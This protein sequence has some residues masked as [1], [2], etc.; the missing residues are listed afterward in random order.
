MYSQ[1]HI[2]TTLIPEYLTFINTSLNSNNPDTTKIKQYREQIRIWRAVIL[3]NEKKKYLAKNYRTRY[4]ASIAGVADR[5]SSEIKKGYSD[6]IDIIGKAILDSKLSYTD[7]IR[8]RLASNFEKN[9]SFDAGLGQYDESVETV[10]LTSSEFT[11]DVAIAASV[12][13]ELGATINGAGASLKVKGS[14]DLEGGMSLTQE[15]SKS[16][17]IGFTIKDN[18]NSNYLSVDVINAFDGNG[19]IFSTLGGRTSCPYEGSETSKF[20]P[21]SK[22][23]NYFDSY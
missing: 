11:Y 4:K 19:P 1:K 15:N 23:K 8:S 7:S 12:E 21:E 2:L 3:D 6:N 5:Y 10:I 17:N 13:Q 9:I 22:F 14:F 20:F 18:D 16:T